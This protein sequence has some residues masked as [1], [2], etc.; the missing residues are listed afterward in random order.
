PGV[1]VFAQRMR[2]AIVTTHDTILE[3]RVKQTR[4]ANRHHRPA[5][6]ELNNLVYLSTKNLKL[7]KKRAW[8]LVPKYIGPFRIV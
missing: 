8:K 2:D 4:Q 7:P 6:F 3:A 5:P 1:W